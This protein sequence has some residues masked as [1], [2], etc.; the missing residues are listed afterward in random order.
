MRL[1]DGSRYV[2]LVVGLENLKGLFQPKSFCD[3]KGEVPLPIAELDLGSTGSSEIPLTWR[4]QSHCS[5]SVFIGIKITFLYFS[6][7]NLSKKNWQQI[8]V[9]SSLLGKEKFCSSGTEDS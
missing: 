3:Y 1:S 6:H 8:Q 2:R 9:P 4:S 7:S 5:V